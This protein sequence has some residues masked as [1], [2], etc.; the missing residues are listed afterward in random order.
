MRINESRRIKGS[1]IKDS[2]WVCRPSLIFLCSTYTA[3]LQFFPLSPLFVRHTH[4]EAPALQ[5]QN[6]W[7]SLFLTHAPRDVRLLSLLSKANSRHFYSPNISVKQHC[8]SLLSVCIICV[9]ACVFVC[10]RRADK[11]WGGSKLAQ[12]VYGLSKD[13]WHYGVG[14][15]P[16]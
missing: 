3:P 14:G 6:P 12:R 15:L 13:Q 11:Y 8:L 1:G 9:R 16:K 4:A 7:L 10:A 2:V 5:P